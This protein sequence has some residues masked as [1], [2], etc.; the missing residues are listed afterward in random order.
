MEKIGRGHVDKR[1]Y[2]RHGYAVH[3]LYILLGLVMWEYIWLIRVH[4][5]W[6]TPVGCGDWLPSLFRGITALNPSL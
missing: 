5:S 2:R 1:L 4:T 6:M 3:F